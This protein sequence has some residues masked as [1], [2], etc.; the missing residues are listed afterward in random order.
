MIFQSWT[1][2]DLISYSLPS[3]CF[4]VCDKTF[5]NSENFKG[6]IQWTAR[7]LFPDS[8]FVNM[9]LHFGDLFLHVHLYTHKT[10]TRDVAWVDHLPT[11]HKGLS[12]KENV[13]F[14]IRL[15][16][17]SGRQNTCHGVVV[18]RGQRVR[19]GS[20]LPPWG[21]NSRSQVWWFV[22]ITFICRVISLTP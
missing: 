1:N 12:S 17:L 2:S 15:M 4:S 18:V 20:L 19:F 22:T 5:Q 6:T 11:I 3:F 21:S 7:T 16:Y 14:S 8:A 10:R 13:D 9:L